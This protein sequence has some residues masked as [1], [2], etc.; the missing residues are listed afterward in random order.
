MKILDILQIIAPILTA[1]ALGVLASRRGILSPEEIRGLQQFAVKFGLPCVVFN[2][3]LTAKIGAEALATMALALVPLVIA[4]FWAFRARSGALA[5]Y[6]LPMLFAAH[7]TGMLGIPLTIALFG[8]AE[9][10]RMGVLDLAQAFIAFPVIAILSSSAGE[11]PR[12]GQI[13]RCV[14]LSADDYESAGPGPE[15][16]RCRRMAGPDGHGHHSHGLHRIP[17]TAGERIDA[18]LRGL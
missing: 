10:Y 13:L 15:S 8:A 2:A 11:N 16:V 12:P 18:L 7:E 4:V 14:H 3:C 6:N 1:V 9:S 17:G 5:Y